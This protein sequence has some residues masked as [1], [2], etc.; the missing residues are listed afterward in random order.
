MASEAPSP[1][2]TGRRRAGAA[3]TE[4]STSDI[5]AVAWPLGQ[6][7]GGSGETPLENSEAGLGAAATCLSSSVLRFAPRTIAPTAS[8][9]RG[10]PRNSATIS[11]TSTRYTYG[12]AVAREAV[13]ERLRRRARERRRLIRRRR[14]RCTARHR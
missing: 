8:T 13:Q 10:R 12:F 4:A 14:S 5:T 7:A 6:E 11:G 1:A 2:A 3:S 9:T